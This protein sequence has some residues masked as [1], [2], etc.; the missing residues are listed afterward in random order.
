TLD[1]AL[2]FVK[3]TI[4]SHIEIV[5]DY[6]NIGNIDS[7]PGPLCQVFV[8]IL[9]NG[10]QA[11]TL[12]ENSTSEKEKIT[13]TTKKAEKLVEITIADT[14]PGIC[15][16]HQMNIFDPFFTTK[17]VGEGTGLGLSISYGIIK[18]L[19]GNIRVSSSPD[20]GTAFTIVLP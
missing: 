14:G 16:E 6:D 17:E 10:I 1:S 4:P 9:T 8:N 15:E 12:K 18:K 20:N 5:K 2:R 11:I 7:S 3:S 19:N 13:I